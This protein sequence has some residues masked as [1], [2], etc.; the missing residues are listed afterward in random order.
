MLTASQLRKLKAEVHKHLNQKKDQEI[1]YTLCM[2]C[3]SKIVYD[4]QERGEPAS[5]LTVV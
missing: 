2:D 5:T 1:Y 4:P 3:F